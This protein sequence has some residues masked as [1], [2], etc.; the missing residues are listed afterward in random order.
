MHLNYFSATFFMIKGWSSNTE[1]G[2]LPRTI[3]NPLTHLFPAGSYQVE[4]GG[5]GVGWGLSS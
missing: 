2:G 5:V 1:G 4:G 3:S